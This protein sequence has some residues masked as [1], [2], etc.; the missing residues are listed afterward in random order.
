[1][2]KVLSLIGVG[3]KELFWLLLAGG[4]LFGGY[5]GFQYLKENK[6]TIEVSPI[7]R[8]VALVESTILLAVDGP[9]PIRGEGFIKPFR[10]VNLATLVAGQITTISPAL[11][12]RTNFK[13]GDVLVRLDN[14]TEKASLM[15][16]EANLAATQ[17]RLDLNLKQLKRTSALQ[18]KG[19]VSLQQL[20][21]RLGEQAELQAHLYNH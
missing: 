17:A 8:P 7:E 12:N 9:L 3:I 1:M 14:L 18:A 15:Q 16:T 10:Q 2:N 5:S 19:A 4:I 6:E 13:K 11:I 20:D 21:N